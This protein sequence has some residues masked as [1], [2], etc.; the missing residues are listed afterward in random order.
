MSRVARPR[1]APPAD[2]PGE[3]FGELHRAFRFSSFNARTI[4]RQLASRGI[5]A[6]DTV[7]LARALVQARDLASTRQGNRKIDPLV[8]ARGNRPWRLET[9]RRARLYASAAARLGW[10]KDF[11]AKVGAGDEG[12]AR[13]ATVEA[14]ARHARR[15]GWTVRH[16]SASDGRATSRYLRWG[17]LEVRVSD[18]HL[19]ETWERSL[20]GGGW[21]FE[22]VVDDWA[23]ATIEGYLAKLSSFRDD[24]NE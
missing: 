24:V 2:V 21:S 10:R 6:G 1:I 4:A 13:L 8:L 5:A 18:H 9:M 16:T 22:I 19:P 7:G 20:R 23:T 14:I 12:E 11:A 15:Q 17:D 3:V